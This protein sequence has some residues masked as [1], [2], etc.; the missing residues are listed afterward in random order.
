MYLP[1]ITITI[2]LLAVLG[3]TVAHDGGHRDESD[4]RL[5]KGA[6]SAKGGGGSGGMGGCT[7]Y[8]MIGNYEFNV[9]FTFVE[10]DTGAVN[11]FD[12]SLNQIRITPI[13]GV[14]NLLRFNYCFLGDR[15]RVGLVAPTTFGSDGKVGFKMNRLN[16]EPTPDDILNDY[17]LTGEYDCHTG[18]ILVSYQAFFIAEAW[19]GITMQD[20]S[21]PLGEDGCRTA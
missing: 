8:D 9:Q 17:A 10:D 13:D 11:K 12:D 15:S 3:A 2:T 21:L 16:F 19:T 18:K 7:I 14:D 20:S 1:L 4:R 6:K 5:A